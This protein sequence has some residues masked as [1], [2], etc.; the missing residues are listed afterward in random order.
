MEGKSRDAHHGG[1]PD[2]GLSKSRLLILGAATPLT[3]PRLST[4]AVP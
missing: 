2:H 3:R 4:A 1:E